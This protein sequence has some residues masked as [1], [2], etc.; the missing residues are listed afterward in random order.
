MM[1]LAFKTDSTRIS[2]MMLEHEGS[3]RSFKD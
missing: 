3:N 1:V 2:T